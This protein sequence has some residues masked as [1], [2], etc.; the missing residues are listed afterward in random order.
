[1][2]LML[3]SKDSVARSRELGRKRK[4]ETE[5]GQG[6]AFADFQY[7]LPIPSQIALQIAL[8]WTVESTS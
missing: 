3:L 4:N 2:R 6:R 8:C 7:T 5:S 1:M